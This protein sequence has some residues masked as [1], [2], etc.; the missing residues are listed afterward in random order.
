MLILPGKLA[1]TFGGRGERKDDKADCETLR[2]KERMVLRA[3]LA[4]SE[5]KNREHSPDFENDALAGPTPTG[6]APGAPRGG[7]LLKQRKDCWEGDKK[8]EKRKDF[9]TE[10]RQGRSADRQG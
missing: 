5:P 9:W 2:L 1:G 6:R 4:R 10:K 8:T 7:G 3:P